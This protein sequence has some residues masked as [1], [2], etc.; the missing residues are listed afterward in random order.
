M[1]KRGAGD[2]QM[3]YYSSVKCSG[4]TSAAA[5]AEA[6]GATK[7][8]IGRQSTAAPDAERD[9]GWAKGA[10]AAEGAETDAAGVAATGSHEAEHADADALTMLP[11][12]PSED[13]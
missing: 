13:S 2:A 9:A 6:D 1:G 8:A 10:V 4:T 3:S 7:G 5:A 11:I 12:S